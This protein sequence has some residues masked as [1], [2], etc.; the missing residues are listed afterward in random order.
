MVVVCG[1]ALMDVFAAGPTAT[2]LMLDARIGGSPLNVAIGLRRLGQPAAFFGGVSTGFLGD[3]LMQALQAEHVDTACTVRV[4]AP[5]T[6]S[7]VGVDAQGV[8]NYAFYGKGAADRLLPLSALDQVPAA[9]AYQFGSYAM[10]VEP[11]AATQRALIERESA[12]EGDRA[13]IAYDPNIRLNVEPDIQ[14][15]RDALQWML[16]RTQ[17][18]KVSDEDL[19]L[20]YPAV[21]AAELAAQWLAAGVALVVVTRGSAGA[22]AWT[23]RHHLAAPPVP[24]PVID[25]VGAGDTFQAALLTALAERGCLNRAALAALS[26]DDVAAVLA[27]A[28]QAAAIT[29]T[30]RGA[31]LPRRTE[32][33]AA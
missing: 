22:W 31:D 17:L 19:G 33:P 24:V 14:R 4:N 11:V 9:A 21:P 18:L 32:L 6:L 8:P 29:C 10:V 28:A 15:W 1:E 27:F 25:T 16:P 13:V 23:A 12:R 3:R 2:G 7:L 26:A 20:L 30:R 5:A